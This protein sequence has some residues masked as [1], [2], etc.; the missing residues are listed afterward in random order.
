MSD[1]DDAER[2]RLRVQAVDETYTGLK[3]HQID[4]RRIVFV[5]DELRR[6]GGY[7]V[8]RR[9]QLYSSAYLPIWLAP[10][11][12]GPPQLV[13]VKQ[14]RISAADNPLELKRAFTKEVLVWSS[15]LTHPGIAKFLGFYADFE[16]SEAWLV[17]PWEPYGNITDFI[18]RREL[19]VP[20]KLS[21]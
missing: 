18:S 4:R 2:K 7:G 9:A 5:R 12:Q 14:I 16:N 13:A 10:R 15:L 17:S 20:E 1:A 8:V 3:Q 6:S 19:E 21:L 11:F